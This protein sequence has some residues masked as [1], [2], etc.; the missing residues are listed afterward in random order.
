[1][2]E[3]MVGAMSSATGFRW[4]GAMWRAAGLWP[5]VVGRMSNVRST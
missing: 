5:A 1:V 4:S 2:T 3:R